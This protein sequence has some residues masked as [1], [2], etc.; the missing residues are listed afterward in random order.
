MDV[1]VE[2]QIDVMVENQ[3]V[4]IVTIWVANKVDIEAH[5]RKHYKSGKT[6]CI[7]Y[8]LRRQTS[9]QWSTYGV[10][11]TL[12]EGQTSVNQHL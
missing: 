1:M 2:N 9:G 3:V 5:V 8:R 12:R 11:L 7:V 6:L 10:V 4:A